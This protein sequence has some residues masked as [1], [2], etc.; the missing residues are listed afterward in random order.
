MLITFSGLDGA[1]KS[2]LIAWLKAELERR[3]RAVT[4]LHMNDDVGVYAYLQR[5]RD[6]LTGVR[7][8]PDA[9]RRDPA[10]ARSALRRVRDAVIWSKWVRRVLYPVDLLIFLCYRA[11]LEWLRGRVLITDRYFYDRLVDVAG[12]S[13]W[14]LLRVLFR[15]TPRPDVPILLDV[16]PEESFARKGEH[17]VPYLRERYMAYRS[18]FPW[19]GAPV[20][21]ASRDLE[22]TKH[23]LSRVVLERFATDPAAAR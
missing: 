7:R 21:L 11:Y 8:P 15:L 5:L 4:V 3:D 6:L 19:V 16:S 20:I 23:T 10:A 17:S 12:D 9:P 22:A 18:V 2:S 13:G 14:R 1:G